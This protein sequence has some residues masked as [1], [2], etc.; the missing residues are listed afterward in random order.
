MQSTRRAVL[1]ALTA[2]S[3]SRVLGANERVRPGFIGYGLIGKQHVRDFPKQPECAAA[4]RA[5]VWRGALS[6]LKSLGRDAH[7]RAEEDN[8]VECLRFAANELGMGRA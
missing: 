1:G 7:I 6:A 3:Y 8:V 4:A 2:A 5:H